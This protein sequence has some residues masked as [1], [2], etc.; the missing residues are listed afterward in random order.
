MSLHP[1]RAETTARG[2]RMLR[3]AFGPGIAA[4]LEDPAVV[5]VMLNP[6]GRLWIDRLAEGLAD[7]GQHLVFTDGER[8]IRLVAGGTSTG[9]T[10]LTN[11]LLAEVA[12]EGGVPIRGRLH[13][14]R[15]SL[16]AHWPEHDARIGRTRGGLRQHGNAQPR[17]EQVEHRLSADVLR[18]EAG[19]VPARQ[20]ALDCGTRLRSGGGDDEG[21]AH[22]VPPLNQGLSGKGVAL[23]Q[24]DHSGLRPE[25]QVVQ[26]RFLVR[27]KQD[28]DIRSAT[29]QIAEK[30][31]A[32]ALYHGQL[33][34]AM[35][36]HES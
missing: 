2:A 3:T 6:D 7:T 1:L 26:A 13:H 9:K 15:P 24:G 17:A 35:P 10:T 5:E 31:L 32:I 29:A 25:W 12:R 28:R 22:Q 19:G 11:A 4:W 21:L 18:D 30:Q 36:P 20:E 8:I 34:T 16:V 14:R 33:D 23:G 27:P